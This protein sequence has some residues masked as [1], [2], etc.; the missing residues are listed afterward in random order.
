MA[1]HA[2]STREG[3]AAEKLP[4]ADTYDSLLADVIS[5]MNVGLSKMSKPERKEAIAGIHA[6]AENVRKHPA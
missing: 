3:I 6:I 2:I 1:A 4:V 5:E